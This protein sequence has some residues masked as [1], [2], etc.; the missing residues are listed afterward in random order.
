MLAN[1]DTEEVRTSITH[2][3]E[4]DTDTRVR[5]AAIRS[6]GA[7]GNQATL[8]NLKEYFLRSPYPPAESDLEVLEALAFAVAKLA[9][10]YRLSG[11]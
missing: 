9:D 2:L 7:V 1:K 6:L 3:A 5:A 4:S 11:R 8:N 10:K